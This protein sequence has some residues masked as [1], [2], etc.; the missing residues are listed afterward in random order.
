MLR[1]DTREEK[2]SQRNREPRRDVEGI[3][4]QVLRGLIR[5]LD[6][7]DYQSWRAI[8]K[9]AWVPIDARPTLSTI[10]CG[11]TGRDHFPFK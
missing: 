10:V 6:A 7:I 3:S 5:A 4:S 11:T 1:S 9:H 2:R 8:E